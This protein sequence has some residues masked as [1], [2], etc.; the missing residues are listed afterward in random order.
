MADTRLGLETA[1]VSPSFDDGLRRLSLS[2]G[3]FAGGS[4]SVF[5]LD[6]RV[7]IEGIFD[8]VALGA[9]PGGLMLGQP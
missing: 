6:L 1:I 2:L 3:R 9:G 7:V 4:G 8:V 5:E